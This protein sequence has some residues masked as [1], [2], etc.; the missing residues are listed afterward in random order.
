MVMR[1]A[2]NHIF[3]AVLLICF[4]IILSIMN[5]ISLN[6]IIIESNVQKYIY[7][8]FF[9][10]LLIFI[11]VTQKTK[12]LVNKDIIVFFCIWSLYIVS[13]MTSKFWNSDINL[14]E[15]FFYFILLPFCFYFMNFEKVQKT[16]YLA[17]AFASIVAIYS[18]QVNNSTGMVLALSG[19]VL[20]QIVDQKLRPK[21]LFPLVICLFSLLIW[22]TQSRTS[23]LSFI[24]FCIAYIFFVKRHIF[25]INYKFIFSSL[26][27]FPVTFFSLYKFSE[28]L[29]NFFLNKWGEASIGNISSGRIDMWT[30]TLNGNYTFLGKGEDYFIETFGIGDGHNIFLQHLGV[31]G[32]VNFILF[33]MM[34]TFLLYLSFK[35]DKMIFSYYIFYI[36]IGSAENILIFDSRFLTFN[37]LFLFNTVLLIRKSMSKGAINT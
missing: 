26:I 4:F 22:Q 9:F 27:I 11:S 15:M 24:I 6:L 37:I 16:V 31:Y 20:V 19:V 12:L 32:W 10:I 14:M 17:I 13:M 33:T 25:K 36:L 3:N 5:M 8:S 7:M 1:I 29:N 23:L 28:V 2:Y 18:F 34:I 21:F 30:Y 35:I